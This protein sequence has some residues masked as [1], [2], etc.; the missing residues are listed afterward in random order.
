ME[1][2]FSWRPSS[3]Q[4][5]REAGIQEV[6]LIPLSVQTFVWLP[7]CELPPSDLASAAHLLFC[8]VFALTVEPTALSK[9]AQVSYSN[10]NISYAGR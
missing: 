9:H 2:M 5:S 4:V 3:S 1:V 6:D 8:A 7:S 10:N